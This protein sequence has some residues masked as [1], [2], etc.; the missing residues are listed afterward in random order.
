[1]NKKFRFSKFSK[2]KFYI[3]YFF[4]KLILPLEV[5]SPKVQMWLYEFVYT[6]AKF[7]NYESSVTWPFRRSIIETKFGIYKIR[8][9]TSDAANVSPAFERSDINYLL[10]VLQKCTGKTLFLDIGGDLGSYSVLVA[11]RHSNVVVKC[12]EPVAE[13]C[14]LIR[15]NATLNNIANLIK[16]YPYALSNK[17]DDK[18][19]IIVDCATPG[20]S[21]MTQSVGGAVKRIPI[22]ERRLDDIL[23]DPISRYET[24]IMKLDVEGMEQAV[25]EGALKVTSQ[26]KQVILMVEDFVEPSIIEYLESNNWSFL[27][28]VTTYNSWWIKK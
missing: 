12:F 15:E 27:A 13:S 26:G 2:L 11:N 16:V 19:E 18:G 24:I 4:Y 5:K 6:L 17:H 20:S 25:L 22:Q 3:S 21:S 10:R 23:E 9:K 28:K 7:K 1:M 8:S 14:E